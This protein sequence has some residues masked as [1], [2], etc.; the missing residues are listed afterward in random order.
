MAVAGTVRRVLEERGLSW[1]RVPHPKTYSTH[2]SAAAADLP[3]DHI[4]KAVIV[5]D[6]QGYAVVVVPGDHWVKLD[7]LNEETGR[8]FQLAEEHDI[9]PLFPDCLPGAVPPLGPAYGLETF[10]DE[11]LTSLAEVYLEAGDHEQLVRVS[12]DHFLALLQGVRR[13]RFSHDG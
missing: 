2:G 1:E 13:G 4:A 3:V 9:D 8:Q 5:R 11:A 12:G 10:L 6:A 7:T